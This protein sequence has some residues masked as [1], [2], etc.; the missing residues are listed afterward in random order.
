MTTA[1]ATV[2]Q[3]RFVGDGGEYERGEMKVMAMTAVGFGSSERLLSFGSL[4]AADGI[5][6]ELGECEGE[7]QNHERFARQPRDGSIGRR[8]E[9]G[10][11]EHSLE[12]FSFPREGWRRGKEERA[13]SWCGRKRR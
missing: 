3:E 6:G 12:F 7:R 13:G 4:R 2:G 8:R 9:R 11:E 10:C 1:L 5:I